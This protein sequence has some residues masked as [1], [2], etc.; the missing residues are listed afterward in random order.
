[1]TGFDNLMRS[2]Q[3][4]Q[5]SAMGYD[6]MRTGVAQNTNQMIVQGAQNFAQIQLQQKQLNSTVRLQQAEAQRQLSLSKLADM[7][8][9]D[10]TDMRRAQVKSMQYDA[11]MKELALKEAQYRFDQMQGSP[12]D[13][14]DTK[15]FN[16]IDLGKMLEYGMVPKEGVVP[17]G[18]SDFREGTE[19]EI[20]KY[21]KRSRSLRTPD[22]SNQ[23]RLQAKDEQ[24]RLRAVLEETDA[25][26]DYA[27]YLR[28]MGASEDNIAKAIQDRY[29]GGGGGAPQGLPSTQQMTPEQQEAQ[30][31]INKFNLNIGPGGLPLY[32]PRIA[33]Q[34]G[35]SMVAKKAELAQ[36][37]R[38]AAS[39]SDNETV[40]KWSDDQIMDYLTTILRNPNDPRAMSIAA[41]IL[42]D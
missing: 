26:E 7:E 32:E 33:Q 6:Q 19:E 35:M 25:P 12:A 24:A 31:Y 18:I 4:A 20:Q 5:Q 37:F 17:K 30:S 29:Q 11:D 28:S 3:F 15:L 23:A 38:A 8:M 10:M 36:A 22:T 16:E 40:K 27:A 9:V 34:L 13:A 14:L 42:E 1:M 2:Q 39:P 41:S 21:I